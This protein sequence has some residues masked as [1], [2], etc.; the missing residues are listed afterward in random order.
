MVLVPL[1]S[2]LAESVLF[3]S[4]SIITTPPSDSWKPII[5]KAGNVT[6][7]VPSYFY[8]ISLSWITDSYRFAVMKHDLVV[9]LAVSYE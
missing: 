7:S 3:G 2:Y 6:L 1:L 4:S 5:F 9:A 8:L